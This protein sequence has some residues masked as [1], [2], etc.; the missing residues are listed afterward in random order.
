VGYRV[1]LPTDHTAVLPARVAALLAS[2][3]CWIE[4]TRPQRRRFDLRPF[5][6]QLRIVPDALEMDLLVF[7]TGLPRP[8]EVLQ[9]LGLPNLLA[10][11]LDCERTRLELVD[12]SGQLSA[13]TSE[14]SEKREFLIADR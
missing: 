1:S 12:N 6:E 2:S 14:R 5:L 8:E 13:V 11:G 9:A 4:R 7:P 3:E 10:E